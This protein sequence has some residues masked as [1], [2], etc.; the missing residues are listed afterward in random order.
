VPIPEVK[1]PVAV[2]PTT[3]ARLVVLVSGAG[4]LLQALLNAAAGDYPARVV[5]VG[6]DL[7]NAAALERSTAAGVSNFVVP[8]GDFPNRAEWDLALTA[9]VAAYEP[10]LVVLAGFMRLVGPEFLARF[11]GRAINSHP[12]LLPA[13]PGAQAV[14]AALAH[15]VRVTGTSL[16]FIDAGVDAGPIIAQVAV[17]VLDGDDEAALHER[18]KQ[19]ERSML[20]EQVARLVRNGWTIEDR[21][22]SVP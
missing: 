11:D 10:D 8:V 22:V 17:P 9:A 20:V 1:L 4:T 5:A 7:V 6:S 14:A 12:A 18:I 16:I 2:R 21:K 19:A 3:P 15:G 13:F